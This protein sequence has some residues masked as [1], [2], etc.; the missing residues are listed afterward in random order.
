M[1]GVA[2]LPRAVH[3]F[4]RNAAV[5][6]RTWHGSIFSSF[7][8]PMLFLAAMGVGLGT[9]VNRTS[10]GVDGVSYVAFLAPGLLA[11][12]QMQTAAGE[13]TFPV[14]GKIIWDRTYEAMLATPLGV[15]DLLLGELAWV[16]FRLTLVGAVFVG[17]MAGFGLIHSP[18]ALLALPAAVL[19]G[20]AFATPILAF[21][22]SR[23]NDSGFNVLFRFIITPLFLFSG[24][25][26][27]VDRLPAFL[28]PIAWLT[29]L[30]HGVELT[31][32]LTLGTLQ[33]LAA[34]VH[35][36]FLVVVV[37]IGIVVADRTLRRHLVA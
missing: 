14:M 1:S 12:N 2:A 34:A 7:L 10:G 19:N 37:V 20:L 33:P 25:F 3:V 36:A 15:R 30:Y 31:R 9:L 11:A 4:E 8:A 28:Q 5:Y 32:G 23:K 16:T 24:T 22:A 27:P 29:P 6:R 18:L 35:V 26:F 13:T 21:S 17:V